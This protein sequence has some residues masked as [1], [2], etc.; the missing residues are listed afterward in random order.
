MTTTG[1]LDFFGCDSM[2]LHRNAGHGHSACALDSSAPHADREEAER[3]LELQGH[4]EFPQAELGAS[5]QVEDDNEDAEER[6]RWLNMQGHVEI[7]EFALV[8]DEAPDED[9]EEAQRMMDMQG[10]VAI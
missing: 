8:A 1:N 5:E 6:D 7:P 10:Y 3:W 9:A 4:V 2:R